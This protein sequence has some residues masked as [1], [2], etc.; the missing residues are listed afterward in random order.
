MDNPTDFVSH[1]N[2][3]QRG[4]QI[5]HEDILENLDTF[6]LGEWFHVAKNS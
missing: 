1:S 2:R 5:D 3:F 6:T 4:Y